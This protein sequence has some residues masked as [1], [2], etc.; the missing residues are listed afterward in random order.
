[1]GPR[2]LFEWAVACKCSYIPLFIPLAGGHPARSRCYFPPDVFSLILFLS[3]S[4]SLSFF[5]SAIRSKQLVYPGS[6][7]RR[8]FREMYFGGPSIARTSFYTPPAPQFLLPIGNSADPRTNFSVLNSTS[9]F[10]HT[11]QFSWWE[12]NKKIQFEFE[13][14]YIQLTSKLYTSFWL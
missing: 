4:L 10:S 9:H 7:R 1:M 13:Y 3:F 12:K 14:I 2:E 5:L 6:S 8:F 11:T